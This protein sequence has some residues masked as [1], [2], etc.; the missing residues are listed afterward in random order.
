MSRITVDGGPSKG[1]P[2]LA[3]LLEGYV[4]AQ[5]FCDRDGRV[6]GHVLSDR[7]SSGYGVFHRRFVRVVDMEGDVFSGS[8]RAGE[9]FVLLRKVKG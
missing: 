3:G 5:K 8:C 7:T 6:I 1:G 9:S 2:L 4:S